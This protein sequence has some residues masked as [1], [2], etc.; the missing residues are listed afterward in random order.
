MESSFNFSKS[1]SDLLAVNYEED[2]DVHRRSPGTPTNHSKNKPPSPRFWSG[3][4]HEAEEIEFSRRPHFSLLIPSENDMSESLK[5]Y[6]T[7]SAYSK[8]NLAQQLVKGSPPPNV[9]LKSLQPSPTRRESMPMRASY[10]SEIVA[11]V[12]RSSAE[13]GEPFDVVKSMS[14]IKPEEYFTVTPKSV[15]ITGTS[16]NKVVQSTSSGSG[17]PKLLK[18]IN[19][20]PDFNDKDNLNLDSKRPDRPPNYQQALQRNFMIKHS[21][22]VDISTDEI[23]K[24]TETSARAKALYEKSLQRYNEQRS[25]SKPATLTEQ[26]DVTKD[27]SMSSILADQTSHFP[28]NA[29]SSSFLDLG[30]ISQ[31]L[32]DDTLSRR[33]GH[34]KSE[35]NLPSDGP[36]YLGPP[37][38]SRNDSKLSD[39]GSSSGSSVLSE[40]TLRRNS[41]SFNASIVTVSSLNSSDSGSDAHTIQPVR[42]RR[43]SREIDPRKMA[44]SRHFRPVEPDVSSPAVEHNIVSE[45]TST[46]RTEE[47]EDPYVT[48]NTAGTKNPK[49]VYL[50]SIRMYEQ[51]DSLPLSSHTSQSPEPSS[52]T[53]RSSHSTSSSK[54][55]FPQPKRS[56][57]PDS[58]K[59]FSVS[60][61]SNSFNTSVKTPQDSPTSQ[62]VDGCS[63]FRS[64]SDAVD[65]TNN[66]KSVLSSSPSPKKNKNLSLAVSGRSKSDEKSVPR[67]RK[68]NEKFSDNTL[69]RN[70]FLKAKSYFYH[71]E[72]DTSPNVSP[73]PVP[74]SSFSVSMCD[75]SAIDD[76][77]VSSGYAHRTKSNF[78][79]PLKSSAVHQSTTNVNDIKN[80]LPWSVK[81]LKSMWDTNKIPS[82][83]P[84]VNHSIPTSLSHH[85]SKPH[86]NPPPY[87]D[88][89]PFR[90]LSDTYRL[91]TSSNSSAGSNDQ[92][93][94]SRRVSSVHSRNR[95]GPQ[96]V[97]GLDYCSSSE[98]GYSSSLDRQSVASSSSNKDIDLS[99]ITYV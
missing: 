28:A 22:P 90:R 21:I 59:R 87:Q 33:D 3:K 66:N 23:E 45:S 98:D 61:S 18:Y 84:A 62:S 5:N 92:S 13:V 20:D 50:D 83:K 96:A 43:A 76:S 2:E 44:Y 60:L 91:S 7:N 34:A 48:L 29:D 78:S 27:N 85:S 73:R 17:K 6:S 51:D 10:D 63:R 14:S 53:L 31:S 56:S 8:G 99:H 69:Q 11:Q 12:R 19:T 82:S 37:S 49:Q 77:S 80:E 47:E 72:D 1:T 9:I 65:N 35:L 54:T 36:F 79:A 39:T 52:Q 57:S 94:S 38:V 67:I 68:S 42:Q 26:N 71:P 24:Q 16:D 64:K 81:D 86:R 15:M 30:S 4:S 40:S 32:H 74:S 97:N 70:N 25:V 58:P 46:A 75:V 41:D 89:P 95:L 93:A 88:P 55:S